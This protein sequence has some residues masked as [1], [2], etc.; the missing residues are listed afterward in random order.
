MRRIRHTS[1]VCLS[2]CFGCLFVVPGCRSKPNDKDTHFPGGLAGAA[3]QTCVDYMKSDQANRMAAP[4]EIPHRYWANEIKAL[5]PIRVYTHRV[6][7]VAVQKV[8]DGVEQGKYI[9]VIIS[10]YVPQTGDD[11]FTFTDRGQG[12][13]D[14]TRRI[15][16]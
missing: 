3:W 6:N 7:L 4:R 14:F 9:N 10:S 13:Y 15:D 11:G 2:L 16:N 1:L 5:K 8:S 12:V